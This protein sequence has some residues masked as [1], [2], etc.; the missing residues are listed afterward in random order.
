MHAPCQWETTLHCNVVSHWLGA[1]TTWSLVVLC[2]VIFDDAS[3]WNTCD[4]SSLDN[5]TVSQSMIISS[6]RRPI[7]S[8]GCFCIQ[9]PSYLHRNSNYTN[10]ES[11][12]VKRHSLYWNGF[13]TRGLGILR[14]NVIRESNGYLTLKYSQYTPHSS[15][16]R[17]RN[18]L[19]DLSH[20]IFIF[21]VYPGKQLSHHTTYY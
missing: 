11:L 17:M 5:I 7:T 18:S 14:D 15:L 16:T 3:I 1:Y 9:L 21:T 2:Y 19:P 13:Q 12:C 8:R 6:I 4:G 20:T 10:K